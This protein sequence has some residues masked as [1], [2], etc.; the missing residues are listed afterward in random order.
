MAQTQFSNHVVGFSSTTTPHPASISEPTTS[1][2]VSINSGVV[3]GVRPQRPGT[4][5]SQNLYETTHVTLLS[6]RL[7]PLLPLPRL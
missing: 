7:F 3:Q 5:D 4:K 2:L 6:F 1:H